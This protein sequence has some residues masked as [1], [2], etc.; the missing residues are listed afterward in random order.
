MYYLN[1]FLDKF[2]AFI[3]MVIAVTFVLF[4][5]WFVQYYLNKRYAGISGNRFRIQMVLLILSF[6]G[7]LVV[8]LTL[9]VSETTIGQL[10]SLL[11][12]LLSAAI[13]LSATTFVGNIMAGFMLRAIKNFKAGDFIRV[14]EHFGRVTERG[15]LHLEIQ[16]EDRDLTT[17]PNLLLVT[18]PVKV[19]RSSGTLV[20]AEVSLGYDI[21]KSKI[22]DA[23]IKAAKDCELEDPFVL[24]LNLGDFSVT[25][26]LCGLLT[27]IKHLISKQSKLK[28]KMLE[29]LHQSG[30][31]IVSPTFMNQRPISPDKPVIPK[32]ESTVPSRQSEEPNAESIVFDKAEEA[33]SLE[34]MRERQSRMVEQ[35][36]EIESQLKDELDDSEI[37]KVKSKIERYKKGIENLDMQILEFEKREKE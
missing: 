11:G 10:L 14:K 31:E 17:L 1:L 6:I 9:P 33:E 30:I 24:I 3:P 28:S 35:M 26:R 32:M 34:K 20:T 29:S 2:L 15:L 22:E 12:I 27:D 23:L 13:A 16:T 37:L 8:I 7:L 4:A 18:N 19:I 21:P 36:R 5:I 25:Y